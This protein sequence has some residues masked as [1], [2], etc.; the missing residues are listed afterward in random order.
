MVAATI[1]LG[2]LGTTTTWEGPMLTH[3]LYWPLG[4][5]VN[6]N[7]YCVRIVYTEQGVVGRG[8]Q[9]DSWDACFDLPQLEN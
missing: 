2:K 7:K 1:Y 3:I 5:N 6:N 4:A 8:L 9:I